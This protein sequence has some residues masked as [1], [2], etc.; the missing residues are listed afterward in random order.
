[1][2]AGIQIKATDSRMG[3]FTVRD[4]IL[5]DS[6][7]NGLAARLFY[8]SVPLDVQ[9]DWLQEKTTFTLWHPSFDAIDEGARIPEYIAVVENGVISWERV[10]DKAG[11]AAPFGQEQWDKFWQAQ[12]EAKQ[13]GAA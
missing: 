13:G 3:R 7:N 6:I 10:E 2:S 11:T 12:R 4:K 1:M 8:G 5:R 9:R